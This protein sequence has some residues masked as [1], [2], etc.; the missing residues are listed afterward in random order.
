[1][2]V[3]TNGKAIFDCKPSAKKIDSYPLTYEQINLILS[4]EEIDE[5]IEKTYIKI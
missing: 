3:T 4:P 1:M 2:Y 5:I